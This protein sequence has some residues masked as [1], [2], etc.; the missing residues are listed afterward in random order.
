MRVSRCPIRRISE[1]H[2]AANPRFRADHVGSLLRPAALNDAF[3]HFITGAL[4]ETDYQVVL[5]DAI[6]GAIAKQ[7]D[8]GLRSVTD[9]EFE[10]GSCSDFSSPAWTD[11]NW[12]RRRSSFAIPMAPNMNGRPAS[13]ARGLPEGVHYW[14]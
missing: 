2:G 5:E 14:P 13:P 12:N 3:R 6:K 10:R 1:A 4:P 9:G 11:S 8:P 7:E